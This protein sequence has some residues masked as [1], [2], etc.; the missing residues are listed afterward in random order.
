MPFDHSHG[1][2]MMVRHARYA[3]DELKPRCMGRHERRRR[4][5]LFLAHARAR[6]AGRLRQP[7]DTTIRQSLPMPRSPADTGFQRRLEGRDDTPPAAALIHSAAFSALRRRRARLC[8]AVGIYVATSARAC[9]CVAAE[10]AK[11]MMRT[12][13]AAYSRRRCRL[14]G[15]AA[16][17]PAASIELVIALRMRAFISES[18]NEALPDDDCLDADA[19]MSLLQRVDEFLLFTSRAI[20]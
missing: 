18:R 16:M 12:D 13:T 5:S 17:L 6:H 14:M 3:A 2:L 9:R 1:M 15:T 10:V 7:D 20:A 19:P 4:R 11:A 8:A